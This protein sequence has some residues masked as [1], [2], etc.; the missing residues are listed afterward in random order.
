M[1]G[2]QEAGT[3]LAAIRAEMARQHADARRS[4]DA[5]AAMAGRVADS[6][7]RTGRLRLV[8]MGGSHCVNRCAEAVLRGYGIDAA[9]VVA[10][11]ALYAP[12]PS[13]PA[14]TVLT[15][16]SGGSAEIVR[17]LERGDLAGCF[18]LTLDGDSHLARAVPSLTG[19]GGP[20]KAYAAT[21]SLTIS[22]ALLAA[23][24]EALGHRQ[25]ALRAVLD[26]PA[27][28][29]VEPAV[30]T[31]RG[32]H[33]VVF[34]ARTALNGIAEAG[35]LGLL[36]L[37]RMPGFA[38]EGGQFRHGPVEALA[39][40]FG[41]VLMRADDE[42]GRLLP[43][44]AAICV[45]AGVTPVVFDAGDGAPIAG[46][47]TLRFPPA[48]GFAAA[49]AMLPTLQMLLIEIARTRIERVGEPL[50]SQKVTRVE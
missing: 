49:L 21:R 20:E 50:R 48:R 17:F 34:S 14:T 33:A 15:S 5:A 12:F 46:C 11:E 22:I 1:T 4:L 28:V 38:L 2:L 40:G 10:S 25:D 7:R 30:A 39:P 18:G 35:A 41:V 26:A 31:L 8:G 19:H 27:T 23:L 42:A 6:V 9:A 43:G 32:A 29:P 37:A 13:G 16:Q 24:A 44:I 45:D 36:E 3:G 47:V